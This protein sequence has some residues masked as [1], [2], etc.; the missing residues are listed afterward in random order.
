MAALSPHDPAVDQN[1]LRH[2][3]AIFKA[4]L[5]SGDLHDKTAIFVVGMPR[6][7]STLVEQ[8]LASHSEVGSIPVDV[9]VSASCTIGVTT[10][11]NMKSYFST[12]PVQPAG[13]WCLRE[14]VQS[15]GH[16]AERGRYAGAS[17]CCA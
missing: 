12:C 2:I 3:K 1:N 14:R 10:E 11:R 8:M 4:P 7:G 6:S 9:C 17:P 5:V 16:C 15:R 13:M